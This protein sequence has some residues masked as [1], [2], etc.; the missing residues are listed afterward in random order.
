VA[1]LFG[2]FDG[3]AASGEL[4]RLELP[5]AP[6]ANAVAAAGEGAEVPSPLPF[7]ASLS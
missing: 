4:L 1:W 3:S 7:P 5:F 6:T 2:G